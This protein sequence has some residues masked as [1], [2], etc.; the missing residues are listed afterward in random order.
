[1]EDFPSER[2]GFYSFLNHNGANHP[3]KKRD[4]I[5][6]MF[7]RASLPGSVTGDAVLCYNHSYDTRSR[8][9]ENAFFSSDPGL[10]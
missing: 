10:L 1:M 2:Y 5:A 4:R 8:R 7:D 6:E 9:V 3:V